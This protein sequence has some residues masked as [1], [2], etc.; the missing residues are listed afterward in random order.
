MPTSLLVTGQRRALTYKGLLF[1]CAQVIP[2]YS[3]AAAREDAED[4]SLMI[5]DF[6]WNF[7]AKSE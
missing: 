6:R 7:A 5:I 4:V 3:H 2:C 1:L